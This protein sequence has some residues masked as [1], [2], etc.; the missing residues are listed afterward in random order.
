MHSSLKRLDH[1]NASRFIANPLVAV[2]DG[3]GRLELIQ[4]EIHSGKAVPI[5]FAKNG[6]HGLNV[7]NVESYFLKNRIEIMFLSKTGCSEKQH[8]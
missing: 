6:L 5:S 3:I 2:T 8:S 1:I 7:V 4:V